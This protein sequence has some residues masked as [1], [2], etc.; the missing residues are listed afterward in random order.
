MRKRRLSGLIRILCWSNRLFSW[1]LYFTKVQAGYKTNLIYTHC[2]WPTA[3]QKKPKYPT[4]GAFE[5]GNLDIVNCLNR[6]GWWS[7]ALTHSPSNV[8]ESTDNELRNCFIW[9]YTF[10]FM[11]Q[12]ISSV[13]N[14]R[15]A[16]YDEQISDL[17]SNSLT[18]S[19]DSGFFLLNSRFPSTFQS[20]FKVPNYAVELTVGNNSM[21]PK[22]VS[23]SI[24]HLRVYEKINAFNPPKTQIKC[25]IQGV[26]RVDATLSR[27]EQ[28]FFSRKNSCQISLSH[29]VLHIHQ[30]RTPRKIIINTMPLRFLDI[31]QRFSST[32]KHLCRPFWKYA[33]HSGLIR[34]LI[35]L[36][37]VCQWYGMVYISYGILC[38]IM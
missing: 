15:R 21:N 27:S 19:D 5:I 36:I 1:F 28:S 8:I 13:R 38:V 24:K 11:Y 25:R 26:I 34:R 7:Y 4:I 31:Y 17:Q 9:R 37:L 23:K 3:D 30:P 22:T 35:E 20:F 18:I 6:I 29:A 12:M 10:I 16:L 32:T 2:I 14:F 33:A